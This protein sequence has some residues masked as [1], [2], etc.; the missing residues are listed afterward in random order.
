MLLEG[1]KLANV[2]ILSPKSVELMTH[3]Q[4]GKIDPDEA[5]GL[6]FGIDGVKA[7]LEELSTPGEYEWGGFYYTGFRIDPKEQMIV[8]FM[9]QLHPSGGLSQNSEVNVLAYQAIM[10]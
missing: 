9:A 6:G 7:P 10:E 5:F 2:R 8:V 3:D 1:G 4:L